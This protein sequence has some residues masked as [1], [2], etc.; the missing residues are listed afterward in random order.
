MR[1]LLSTFLKYKFVVL[2]LV[3]L[4][5]AVVLARTTPIEEKLTTAPQGGASYKSIVPGISSEKEVIDKLGNPLNTKTEAD[6]K[7]LEY[8]STSPF[9]PHKFTLENNTVILVKEI[10]TLEDK[11]SS[12]VLKQ[13]YGEPPYKLFDQTS[14]SSTFFLFVYPEKGI[15]YLGHQD[16]TVIEVWYFQPTNLNTFMQKYAPNYSLNLPV[17][18][19]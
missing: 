1:K 16:G 17:Q 4:I 12:Q 10:V 13:K 14:Y 11:I 7:I 18:Q 6:K 3:V 9:V 2:I 8:Q 15:A 19:G 5:S